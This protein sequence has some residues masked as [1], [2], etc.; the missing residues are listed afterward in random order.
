MTP[1]VLVNGAG[2]PTADHNFGEAQ[3]E[4]Q[5]EERSDRRFRL[6]SGLQTRPMSHAASVR[7]DGNWRRGLPELSRK[8]P[9][10]AFA[11]G[12]WIASFQEGQLR[13]WWGCEPCRWIRDL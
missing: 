6:W 12:E 7:F 1:H 8:L 3:L 10:Y 4:R 5:I 2:R 13:H 11:F 9:A